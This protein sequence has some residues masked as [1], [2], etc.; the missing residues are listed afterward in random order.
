M[1]NACDDYIITI[2]V[3]W[4]PDWM[5]EYMA[6][7]LIKKHVKSTWFVTHISPAIKI[8]HQRIDLFEIGVHPNCL[9]GSTHGN[10]EDEVLRHIKELIPD[11]ITMRTHALYQST[12]FLM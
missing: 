1:K 8:I 12:P 3:D 10:N 11:A 7:V 2:D 4:A 5:I 9:F 6:N